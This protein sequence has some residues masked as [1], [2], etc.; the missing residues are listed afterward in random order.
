RSYR[1]NQRP[2]DDEDAKHETLACSGRAHDADL[3]A[4][5]H[6]GEQHGTGDA[7]HDRNQREGLDDRSGPPLCVERFEQLFVLIGPRRRLEPRGSAQPLG[8]ARCSFRRRDFD[9]DARDPAWKVEESTS[10]TEIHV[11]RLPVGTSDAEREYSADAEAA[12]AIPFGTHD[13]HLSDAQA[14]VVSE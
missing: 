6:D 5:A 10:G 1:P 11:E 12:L 8:N 9:L 13:D 2:F 4:T 7:D 14:E 3:A